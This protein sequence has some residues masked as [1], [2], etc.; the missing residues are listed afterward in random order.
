[1]S[2]FQVI[3][4]AF[5][6]G[7][8]EFLP[9]SSSGHLIFIPKI[10]S[11][12]DQGLAFDT[13]MHLATLL[14]VILF[15]RKRILTILKSFF[16]KSKE[17]YVLKNKKIA[18]LILVATLPAVFFGFLFENYIDSYFRSS[19]IVAFNLI[20]WAIVLFFADYFNRKIEQRKTI[21]NISLKNSI[22]I[23]FAQALA[24][25]PGT[26]R[27]GITISAGLFSKFNKQDAIE[28]SFLL[29]IPV[30][31]GAGLLQIIKLFKNGLG[32]ISLLSLSLGFLVAFLSGLLAI[33]FLLEIVRKWN[34]LPFVIY[35]IILGLSILLFI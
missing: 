34:F 21:E 11:W 28:F 23:G 8:S 17:E 9:V 2:F 18:Y 13:I 1:M 7:I 16:S 25:L 5:I 22:F 3:T 12:Q 20:F 4:L 6:Q 27:S 32:D 14:A 10:L 29:S 15:F 24:L 35:R 26:S 19:Y 33:K 30:I 31:A